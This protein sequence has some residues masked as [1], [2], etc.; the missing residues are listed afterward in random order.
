MKQSNHFFLMLIGSLF[1]GCLFTLC[2]VGPQPINYG[3]DQCSSCKMIISDSRFGAELVTHKGKIYK[4]DATECMVREFIKSGNEKYRFMLITHVFEP[5]LLK[6][7]ANSFYLVSPDFPSPMGG[8]L[9]AYG[10]KSEALSAQNKFNGDI[11][12]WE[13]LLIEYR[14]NE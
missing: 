13:E 6:D 7:A 10:S 11:Y 8:N 9:S 2:N 12:S 3:S 5:S 1:I 4:Y 14:S